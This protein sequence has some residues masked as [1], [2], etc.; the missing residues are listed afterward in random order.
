M[1]GGGMSLS[2]EGWSLQV[3]GPR[4]LGETRASRMAPVSGLGKGGTPPGLTH[5]WWPKGS[6]EQGKESRGVRERGSVTDLTRAAHSRLQP[7]PPKSTIHS[8]GS[9]YL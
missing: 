4:L 9:G 2:R 1:G 8:L 3:K 7:L 5:L 6:L